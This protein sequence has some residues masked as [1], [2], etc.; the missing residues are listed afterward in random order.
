MANIASIGSLFRK[1]KSASV[2]THFHALSNLCL[3]LC[4]LDDPEF[5]EIQ[6][7]VRHS[8]LKT[9]SRAI[10]EVQVLSTECEEG[11]RV[12]DCQPTQRLC[13]R[14]ENALRHGLKARWFGQSST[15]WP[16][17]LQ[18]SRKQAIEYIS[19]L[20]PFGV[21]LNGSLLPSFGINL[22]HCASL[23]L[24]KYD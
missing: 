19:G 23:F 24:V 4:V 10:K 11:G 2:A 20:V 12:G 9:L 18:I 16:L 6:Q 1:T 15:F 3:C 7:R 17:V 8:L 21:R 22:I 13:T 5:A 14:F